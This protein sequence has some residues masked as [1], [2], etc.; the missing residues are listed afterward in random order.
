MGMLRS[1]FL[2]DLS[3]DPQ[4]KPRNKDGGIRGGIWKLGELEQ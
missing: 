3:N 4:L 2:S 1:H